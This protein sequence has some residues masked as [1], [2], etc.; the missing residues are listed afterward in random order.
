[1]ERYLKKKCQNGIQT[2]NHLIDNLS[3]VSAVLHR[4]Y[5]ALDFVLQ[6]SVRLHQRILN[7]WTK[8]GG[9]GEW[10]ERDKT[11]AP[12]KMAPHYWRW[13]RDCWS[14][15]LRPFGLVQQSQSQVMEPRK[16]IGG[17]TGPRH[18][19]PSSAL[20]A[21]LLMDYHTHHFF[22]YDCFLIGSRTTS[23]NQWEHLCWCLI[24]SP[25]A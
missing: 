22:T 18:F 3:D 8:R 19:L 24:N 12:H 5:L 20:P 10:M 2:R 4:K 7:C 25:K 16:L 15:C 1:M 23:G 13:S 6:A 11:E 14:I 21:F 9:G 17:S